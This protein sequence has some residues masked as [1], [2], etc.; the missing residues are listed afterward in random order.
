MTEPPALRAVNE[1]LDQQL[2]EHIAEHVVELLRSGE[3]TAARL[4]D[5]TTVAKRLGVSRDYVY[6][7]ADELGVRRI[8]S[9]PRPR[10]RFE[11]SRVISTPTSC[12]TGRESLP[13]KQPVA[14]GKSARRQGRSMG[15]GTKLLPIRGTAAP[16]DDD[17]A[18]S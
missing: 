8:G 9:G 13:P 5:A 4:V 2:A 7:H 12:F 1:P 15:S 16:A 18:G 6:A 17:R 3:G 11:L 14:T 10:L